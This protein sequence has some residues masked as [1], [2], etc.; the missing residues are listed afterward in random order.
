MAN[1]QLFRGMKGPLIPDADAVNE[2]RAPAYV[3]EPEKTLAQYCL[4]G[5]LSSTFYCDAET[6]LAKVLEMANRVDPVFVAQTAMYGR[7]RGFMKDMPALLC[8]VLSRREPRL[9]KW[10]FPRVIDNGRM[11]RTF[12]QIM[13]SG[14][15]DRK[16]LG[17]AAKKEVQRWFSRRSDEQIFHAAVGSSPTLAD[18][19]RMAHP[20]PATAAREALFGYLLGKSCQ[21]EALPQSV[22]LYEAWKKG[23]SAVMPDVPFQLLTSSELGTPEW[24]QIALRSSWQTAVMNIN[25]FRRHGVFSDPEVVSELARRISDRE[26]IR[27]A[28]AFPYRIMM[29]YR[30]AA[31]VP[32]PILAALQNAME[33]AMENVPEIAGGVFVCPDVS[34]SMTNAAV[35]GRREGAASAVRCIDVA[36]LAAAAIMRKNPDA[37]VLPFNTGVVQIRLNPRDT[38]LTNAEKLAGIGGGGT[39]C[40]APLAELNRRKAA[41]TL[42]VLISD[43]ESWADARGGRGTETMREWQVFKDRNPSAKLV[44]IDIQPYRTVQAI[45]RPDIVNVGGFSDQVFEVIRLFLSGDLD[46]DHCVE[47][48]KEVEL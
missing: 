35:T 38:V 24:R 33:T 11:L 17:S 45:D 2:E 15:T 48:I 9:M 37:E 13:R 22:R 19:I 25:T 6:Q 34:G 47:M 1:K 26:S 29:A 36:A 10:I 20:R 32:G 12:V 30:M 23:E 16:S 41:G 40:S 14:A 18:V 43:S 27:G 7:E 4:T 5:C 31:G 8:A 39:S 28:R 3:M 44:C 46:G 21:A 42:V